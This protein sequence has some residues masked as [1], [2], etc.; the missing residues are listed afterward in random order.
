PHQREKTARESERGRDFDVHDA[1]P[2]ADIVVLDR[3]PVAQDPR[4]VQETV[5]TSVAL[6]DLI[7]E[8]LVFVALRALEIERGDRGF[9]SELAKLRLDVVEGARVA[10]VQDHWR[11]VLHEGGRDRRAD[12]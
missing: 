6:R 2:R 8:V 12:A 1:L 3:A 7:R 9:G 5:Q 11:P 10:A 4:I